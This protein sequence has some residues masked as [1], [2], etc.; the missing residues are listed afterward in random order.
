M[1]TTRSFLSFLRSAGII[2]LSLGGLLAA[3][4]AA[5]SSADEQGDGIVNA[6]DLGATY[7]TSVQGTYPGDDLVNPGPPGKWV[8]YS[9]IPNVW[10]WDAGTGYAYANTWGA[11][12]LGLLVASQASGNTA[13]LAAAIAYAD[14]IAD[15]YHDS[16]NFPRSQ[17]APFLTDIELLTRVGT[18][19]CT[20]T[21]TNWFSNLPPAVDF[22]DRTIDGSI[23]RGNGD[24]AGWDIAVD[25]SGALVS[26][27]FEYACEL[28]KRVIQRRA[29]WEGSSPADLQDWWGVLSEGGLANSLSLVQAADEDGDCGDFSA[30]IRGYRDALIARQSGPNISPYTGIDVNG[31]IEAKY[32]GESFWGV[33]QNAFGLLGLVGSGKDM[34]PADAEAAAKVAAYLLRAQ[35]PA[36][37]GPVIAGDPRNADGAWPVYPYY[38]LDYS[39]MEIDGEALYALALARQHGI[40]PQAASDEDADETSDLRAEGGKH[41]S[42]AR[43]NKRETRLRSQGSEPAFSQA[44]PP[45]AH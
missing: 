17:T 5:F 36:G 13:G 9:A 35:Y 7:L 15:D 32:A 40:E 26:G 31:A 6:L 30:D 16:G 4:P 43:D 21:A 2:L 14:D 20:C 1:A 29:D 24:L 38:W 8:S 33:Q 42:R 10:E 27:H 34:T 19:G 18:T 11:T 28:A 25:I 23:S 44:G 22:A 3:A 39:N 45:I 12:A 37:T 41:S